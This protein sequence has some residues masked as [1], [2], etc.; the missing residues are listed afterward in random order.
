MKYKKQ[1]I[2][3]GLILIWVYILN[4]FYA[5]ID[6]GINVTSF[7]KN[8]LE[9][10]EKLTNNYISKRGEVT[11]NKIFFRNE[12]KITSNELTKIE[13]IINN[14]TLKWFDYSQNFFSDEKLYS[15]RSS[16]F[17]LLNDLFDISEYY[18]SVN[19]YLKAN[20]YFSITLKIS[21]YFYQNWFINVYSWDKSIDIYNKFYEKLKS[22]LSQEQ[23]SQLDDLLNY[24]VNKEIA[25]DLY[26]KKLRNEYIKM[27]DDESYKMPFSSSKEVAYFYIN[28]LD[29]YIKAW[30]YDIIDEKPRVYKV[31]LHKTNFYNQRVVGDINIWVKRF[32][33]A[34]Y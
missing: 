30:N 31:F 6:Y 15:W 14:E 13:N 20:E 11:D 7:E 19:N 8:N 27:I 29:N 12:L 1:Y 5:W 17:N 26:L 4:Y 24:E 23:I 3:I 10:Y 16:N 28:Y 33:K 32:L 34:E 25:F 18:F 2:L 22:N 21:N 9:S